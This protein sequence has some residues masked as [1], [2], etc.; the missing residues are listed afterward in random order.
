MKNR[1]L[2][3]ALMLMPFM[4]GC[5]I[6]SLPQSKNATEAALAE[7]NNQYKRRADLI[8]NLVNVVKGYA[9][10]EEATLTAVTE[11]RAKATSMQI[12]PSKVTPE[13]LAKFQQAQSG[14]SQALGRLMVVSEQY[15]QLKADQNFRDLQAQL[16]GTENRIT[17]A[18]Q[19]YIETINA[20]NNQVSVPPTSWTNAIMYHF[21]KMPQW[22]MTPE[23]KASAEKAPEVKF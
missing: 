13:Q 8:P 17:I 11:A 14:L 20:F 22:D 10:H 7:V 2:V 1:I 23:E 4:V 18:R 5:G 9:K 6:Q 21:E 16:E 12:D 15:P 3:L 19:R